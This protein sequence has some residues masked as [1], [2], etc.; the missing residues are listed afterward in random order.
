MILRFICALAIASLLTTQ[1]SAKATSFH[2]EDRYNPQ[3]IDDLPLDVRNALYRMCSTPR[4]L[5][6][7]ASYPDDKHILLHFEH[8]Y[9]DQ[10]GAFCKPSGCLHQ[11]YRSTDGHYRLLRTYYAPAGD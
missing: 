10:R 4:A 11:L 3:H 8:F 6:P 7:F 5:H 9:C 1:A 2:S